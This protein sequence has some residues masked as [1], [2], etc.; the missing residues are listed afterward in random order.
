MVSPIYNASTPL[1]DASAS[2]SVP[3][4]GVFLVLPSSET[5]Q[6]LLP[7][8]RHAGRVASSVV[9]ALGVLEAA[10]WLLHWPV[11]ANLFPGLPDMKPNTAVCIALIGAGM[12]LVQSEGHER[13]RRRA[14]QTMAG[15]AGLIAMGTLIEHLARVGPTGFDTW[16]IGFGTHILPEVPPRMAP[17][18]AASILI[19]VLALLSGGSNYFAWRRPSQGLALLVMCSGLWTLLCTIFN[20]VSHDHIARYSGM[21]IPTALALVAFGIAVLL[22]HPESGVTAVFLSASAAGAMVR[23]ILPSSMLLLIAIGAVSAVGLRTGLYDQALGNA[24]FAIS[25]LFFVALL[26]WR[27]AHEIDKNEQE[28]LRAVEAARAQR[29]RLQVMLSSIADAVIATDEAGR[30]EFLNPVAETLTGWRNIEAVGRPTHEVFCVSGHGGGESLE[31]PVTRVIRDTPANATREFATLT[32]RDGSELPIEEKAAPIRDSNG[33]LAGCVVVFRDV[34]ER[35]RA[36]DMRQE[37]ARQYSAMAEAIPQIVW[38]AHADGSADFFNRRWFDYTGL[39]LSQSLGWRWQTA[40]HPE[41]GIRCGNRWRLSVLSGKGFEVEARIR[42]GS[43]GDLRWQLIRALPVLDRA[44]K[45]G[46]W[47]GTCTDI[48]D[49]KRAEESLRF[50]ADASTVLSRSLDERETLDGIAQLAVPKI[51]DLCMIHLLM[52]GRLQL[53]AVSHMDPRIA[54]TLIRIEKEHAPGKAIA[55][56]V[57]IGKPDLVPELK[58]SHFERLASNEEHRILLRELGLLS[59]V[60][61]PLPGHRDIIGVITFVSS[62]RGRC[63]SV[64]DLAPAEEVARRTALA[65]DN[66]RLFAVVTETKEEAEAANAAK[67][68]FLAVLSHELR[69]PLTPVLLC[70]EALSHDP[71]LT[72]AVRDAMEMTRRNIEL[73][74]RLI[75]DLLDL[76]R[77]RRGKLQLHRAP[78]DVHALL[79]SSIGIC[80]ADLRAK[81]LRVSLGLSAV[82][83]LVHT[84][85]ARLQQV[86]W[87]LIKNAVKF[88]DGGGFVVFRTRN[89]NQQGVVRL[90]VEIEDSGI[91]IDPPLLP[92]IFN[93]FEQG[94]KSRS[95]RF[96]GLGLGLAIT[97]YLV[98]AHGG[99]ISVQSP[100]RDLGT[101]FTVEL[102]TIEPAAA[103]ESPQGGSPLEAK[104]GSGL[105]ILLVEDNNDT[106]VLLRKI[107]T[108]RGYQVDLATSMTAA[109]ATAAKATFDLLV[110]DVG[111]P[112]G[113]GLQL[114]QCL[115][116][117]R[118]IPGIAM[119]GFGMD[120]DIRRSREAG[121]ADHLTKPISISKLEEAIEKLMRDRIAG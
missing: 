52:Q 81:N 44:G 9:I 106:G 105:R 66:N 89:V 91:G 74:A 30:V 119:S 108:R 78:T 98:D 83:H 36:D 13:F 115:R 24:L 29:E 4:T 70:V 109:L 1:M 111:L 54:D 69:T 80:D 96:G 118:P 33:K 34:T 20:V 97:K 43:N 85:P 25:S 117:T 79:R 57:A 18:T 82:R 73:E 87:N 32:A 35:R 14:M 5:D 68:Q 10:G 62:D 67:D 112:D 47:F 101:K 72:P 76:T 42:C 71:S 27:T 55:D 90:Q 116:E 103:G 86:F 11:L 17:A 75:D 51:A 22:T 28:R 38:T 64:R 19:A 56:V 114:M 120:E 93:A 77:I 45:I 7:T 41:D 65:L 121:F 107:L 46:K 88:T 58:E 23:T 104:A 95:R 21:A 50:L 59:S 110:S 102:D 39:D 94:E 92:K 113:S 12:R 26:V 84:D 40:L 31:G 49:Q 8:L 2:G 15:L 16:L 3:L 6:T 63:Y 48:D 60:S 99:S 61:V 100:G 53:A 37:V